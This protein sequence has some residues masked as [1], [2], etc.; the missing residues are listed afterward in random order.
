MIRFD[1]HTLPPQLWAVAWPA[2]VP[3]DCP[4][5]CAFETGLGPLWRKGIHK[6]S[7]RL[8]PPGP[9]AAGG[10]PGNGGV[11][12]SAQESLDSSHKRAAS[13]QHEVV[14]VR[15]RYQLNPFWLMRAQISP[16][17]SMEAPCCPVSP[18]A[19][20]TSDCH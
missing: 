19:W 12:S 1:S 18:E 17:P 2:V 16:L 15:R 4:L 7:A 6:H 11:R 9:L 3:G 13:R 14:V 10:Q 8:V 20:D 5:A